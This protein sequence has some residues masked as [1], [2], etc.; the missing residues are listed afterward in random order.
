MRIQRKEIVVLKRIG[1]I[2]LVFLGMI[3]CLE[4]LITGLIYMAPALIYLNQFLQSQDTTSGPRTAIAGFLLSLIPL[5][6]IL[7]LL[8]GVSF[9]CY[10]ILSGKAAKIIDMLRKI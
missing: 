6:M 3:W 9:G 7:T 1:K 4:L 10:L 5:S 2:V 8:F